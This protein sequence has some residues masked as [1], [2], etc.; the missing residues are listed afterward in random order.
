MD[1]LWLTTEDAEAFF[2]K[3]RQLDYTAEIEL[4][5][6]YRG[7]DSW[8][9]RLFDAWGHC[10]LGAASANSVGE[11][12]TWVLGGGYELL[13]EAASWV[14]LNMIA[15]DSFPQDTYNQAVGRAIG[16]RH[17]NG[18]YGDLCY[19]AMVEGRLDLTLAGVPRGTRLTLAETASVLDQR[20]PVR[21]VR[22]WIQHG[23]AMA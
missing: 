4:A 22:E 5:F 3:I 19:D 18:N 13:H 23:R 7:R 14:S 12:A 1:F 20:Q 9:M 21:R 6:D 15:H 8:E 17:P 10:Y 2:I 16:V 11:P